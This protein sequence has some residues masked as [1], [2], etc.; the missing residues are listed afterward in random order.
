M[1]PPNRAVMVGRGLYWG[2]A[3]DFG[4]A[5]HFLI[6]QIENI[7]RYQM[8]AAGLNTSTANAE[9]IVNE[10]GLSTLMDVDGVDDVLGADVAFEIKALFCSPFGPNLRNVFAHGLIDDDAFYT[11][12]I[13]YAWWFMLKLISTPYWNGM[14]EAQRNAQQGS[15][16][17]P[18]SGS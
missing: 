7:V 10:N 3:G 5:A 16:K 6:P 9:G 12:P 11:I 8:K 15:A 1:V 4:M 17:P 13:V 14:V 2:F 18:E